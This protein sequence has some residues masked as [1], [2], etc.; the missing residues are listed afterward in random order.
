MLAAARG[1]IVLVIS[2]L[3]FEET[4][5]NLANIN[6]EKLQALEHINQFIPFEWVSPSRENVMEATRVVVLKD[7]PIVAAAKIARVDG[8]IT[9]DRKHILNHP[10]IAEYA[11]TR[12][13]TPKE[14]WELIQG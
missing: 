12:L 2:P 13:L 4:K 10:E 14:A 11:K 3:V 8:L 5:R 7:A 6:V 1:N 9:L